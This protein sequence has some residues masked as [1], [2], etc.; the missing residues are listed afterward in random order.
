MHQ[1]YYHLSLA[2]R[3]GDS[4]VV[5]VLREAAPRL[6]QEQNKAN[7]ETNEARPQN[8]LHSFLLLDLAFLVSNR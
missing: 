7:K 2:P 6:V 3:L 5:Q 8:S 4:V 1:E